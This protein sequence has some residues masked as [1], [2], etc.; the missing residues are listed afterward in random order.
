MAG[1]DLRTVG[2]LLGHRSQQM[3]LRYSHLAPSRT[4]S[5]VDRLVV[6]GT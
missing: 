4:A 2:E 6:S 3:T 5:A 1:V